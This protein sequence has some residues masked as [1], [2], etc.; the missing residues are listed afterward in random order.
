[1]LYTKLKNARKYY[2]HKVTKEITDRYD[3]ITSETLK[4]KQMIERKK[5]SKEITDASFFEIIRQIKYKSEEKGK[6][7]Y[8]IN[9]YYASSQICSRCENKDK[10]YKDLKEREYR[11]NV[12]NNKEDRDVNASIN[13]MFE[14]LKLYM[15]ETH[16]LV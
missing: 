13:I 16:S 10:K 5:L 15:K 6:K 12:C 7:F 1:M 3:I 8:Q 9:E 11:C 2:L 4:T 14:G